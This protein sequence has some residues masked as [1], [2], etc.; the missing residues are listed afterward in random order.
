MHI[1]QCGNGW[2]MELFSWDEVEQEW[3]SMGDRMVYQDGDVLMEAI[4]DWVDVRG[5]G[6]V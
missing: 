3:F 5:K 4:K 1:E 2:L 6:V